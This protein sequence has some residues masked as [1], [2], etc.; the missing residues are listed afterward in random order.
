MVGF[1]FSSFLGNSGLHGRVEADWDQAGK[2]NEWQGHG[3]RACRA[4]LPLHL[5]P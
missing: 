2:E 3:T 5:P 1:G 4:K